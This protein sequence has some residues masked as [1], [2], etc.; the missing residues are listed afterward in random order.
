MFQSVKQKAIRGVVALTSRT[1]V[2]Q[3]ISG[4]GF[5]L[6][7][8]FLDLKLFGIFVIVQ[9]ASSFLNYFSDVGLAAALIQKKEDIT[10]KDLKTTFTVQQT[11]VLTIAAISFLFA[12]N[13]IQFY[14]L[15][16]EGVFLFKGL[17]VAFVFSSFK[18]IP[19]ILLER[20]LEFEKLIIPQIAEVIT[21]YALTVSLAWKGWGIF[22]LTAGVMG[23]GLV[24][25]IMM[26]AISPWM[27]KIGID[28]SS[29][30]KLLSFGVPMQLN[31]LLALV[32]DDL[33]ILYLGAVL[34]FEQVS[35]IGWAKK[36]SEMPLRLMM[37]SVNRVIFP[38]F[39]RLQNYPEKLR[40]GIEKSLLLLSIT[41]FPVLTGFV[42]T[43]KPL[44][45]EIPRY[46]KWEPALVSF[47]LF[48]FSSILASFSTPLTNALNAIGKVK[49]TLILMVLW[50]VLTW[51]FVPI[52]IKLIGFQGVAVSSVM[53]G[54][55]IIVTVWM[56]RKFL[57]FSFLK[58]ITPAMISSMIMALAVFVVLQLVPQGFI[59][60]ILTAVFG[61]LIYFIALYR[62]RG[63]LLFAYIKE[64][65]LSQGS[66]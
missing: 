4:I 37:D 14:N 21:F 43:A 15:S 27:P 7:T 54:F 22:S 30:R 49:F 61:A 29:L 24:G 5:F 65:R 19:S 51:F 1:A 47:Y 64:W 35:F 56:T 23:R 39:S 20:K 25:L 53:I 38:T 41:I 59:W 46:N 48:S 60:L 58:E 32:K 13:V 3:I 18:T 12:D 26:Y 45:D 52:S 42:L 34:S 36:W 40:S 44:I 17:I 55:T 66:K 57:S 28:K 9:A 11:L 8:I 6:L 31:S 50:T 2:V 10:E 16:F 33:L 62:L 63:K